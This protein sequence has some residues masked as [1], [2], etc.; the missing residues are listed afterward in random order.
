MTGRFSRLRRKGYRFAAACAIAAVGSINFADAAVLQ[1]SGAPTADDPNLKAWYHAGA[2]LNLSGTNVLSWVDQSTSVPVAARQLNAPVGHEPTLIAS[3]PLLGGQPALFFNGDSNTT[4]AD[5]L[6]R[7][8]GNAPVTGNT[9]RTVFAVVS[10][11]TQRPSTNN[12]EHI[13][14]F[15]NSTTDRAY[16]IV[17]ATSTTGAIRRLGNHYWGGFDPS[18]SPIGPS[19]LVIAFNYDGNAIGGATGLDQFFINGYFVGQQNIAASGT[20]A[21]G[22]LNTGPDMFTVGSRIAPGSGVNPV[23]HMRGNIAEIIIYDQSLSPAEQLAVT[24]YLANKYS[25]TLSGAPSLGGTIRYGGGAANVGPEDFTFSGG[26]AGPATDIVDA[27]PVLR[28]NNNTGSQVGGAYLTRPVAFADDHSFSAEFSVRMS[29]GS[30]SDCCGDPLGADGISFVIS[31]DPRGPHAVGQSGG[32]MGITG[33]A[34][35]AGRTTPTGAI[36]KAMTITLDTWHGGSFDTG[37]SSTRNGNHLELN[38]VGVEHSLVQSDPGAIVPLNNA[39]IRY[40]WVDY[41][42]GAKR[43]NAYLSATDT[44]PL[45]PSITKQVDLSEYFGGSDLYVGFLGATGG[46]INTHDVRTFEITSTESSNDPAGGARMIWADDFNDISGWTLNNG[47]NAAAGGMPRSVG[48][49]LRLTDVVNEAGGTIGSQG[50]SAFYNTPILIPN[51]LTWDASFQ[52]EISQPGGG[53]D[54]A[55]GVGADGLVFMLSSDP[56]GE[57]AVGNVGGGM[58]MDLIGNVLSV[59]IDTWPSGVNDPAGQ[60]GNHLGINDSI[61]GHIASVAFPRFNDGGVYNTQIVFDGETE[62]MFVWV[63][64]DGTPQPGAPSLV[65]EVDWQRVFGPTREVYVGFAAGTGGATNVHE[66]LN[67][68]FNAVPEPTTCALIAAGLAGLVTRRRRMA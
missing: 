29:Q 61:V 20:A 26:T 57:R 51:N 49:R 50:G 56:W 6:Q 62:T 65:A 66:V 55:D 17:G 4:I 63:W 40:V 60:N 7:S 21:G 64:L 47:A 33:G 2:G 25:V 67:L 41:D 19:P 48:G 1:P 5:L 52:F 14:H 58:G 27:A 53:N 28:L 54:G 30:G 13:L 16:G 11:F 12:I 34:V 39:E 9:D 22:V 35:L 8:T 10:G 38:F 42:G 44:K 43:L 23:E 68:H 59:E 32:S 46:A 24:E 31:E 3:D 37:L 15:G 18:D 45:T 36:S